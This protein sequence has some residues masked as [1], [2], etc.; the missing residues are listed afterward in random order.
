MIR[1]IRPQDAEALLE[2]V[3]SVGIFSSNEEEEIKNRL[4][5][6]FQGQSRSL[7]IAYGEKRLEGVLY[8]I[9]EPMTHGTWNVL[10]LLVREG[11]QGKGIGSSLM[12]EAQKLLAEQKARMLVV[13]TSGTDGFEGAQ[14][15]YVKCGFTEVARIPEF[16]DADDD[17]VIFTKTI[18]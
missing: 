16:Y 7:W 3:N 14:R 1:Q 15:F 8:S 4:D 9:P 6:H 17:K 11:S 5:E 18:L 10:M 2:L 12:K 13:E